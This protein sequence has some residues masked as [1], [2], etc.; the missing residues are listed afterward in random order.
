MP[1]AVDPELFANLLLWICQTPFVASSELEVRTPASVDTLRRRLRNL[2]ETGLISS[3]EVGTPTVDTV[4]RYYPTLLGISSA[5]EFK[6]LSVTEFRR[7]YPVSREW[8]EILLERLDSVIA[9]YRLSGWVGQIEGDHGIHLGRTRIYDTGGLYDSVL[10]M[11]DGR[12]V[13]IVR[14]GAAL[15]E[16]DLGDALRRLSYVGTRPGAVLLIAPTRWHRQRA[17]EI[18]SQL[19]LDSVYVATERGTVSETDWAEPIWHAPTVSIGAMRTLA[20]IV[21]KAA[22]YVIANE[23]RVNG[24]IHRARDR[25]SEW[26]PYGFIPSVA[27]S[28]AA[29]VDPAGL[30]SQSPAANLSRPEKRILDII[31]ACPSM[32]RSNLINR[33]GCTK[34]WISRV[35]KQLEATWG[36][37][38]GHLNPRDPGRGRLS[39]S[40][41]GC[42]YAAGRDRVHLETA[43]DLWSRMPDESGQITGRLARKAERLWLHQDGVYESM[44]QLGCGGSRDDRV[45]WVTSELS[46]DYRVREVRRVITPDA[47]GALEAG[48][49]YIPFFLEFERTAIYPSRIPRRLARYRSLYGDG[50][51]LSA[52]APFPFVLFTFPSESIENRFLGVVADAG[53]SLPILTSNLEV[54]HALGGMGEAWRPAWPLPYPEDLEVPSGRTRTWDPLGE[55]RLAFDSLGST[56]WFREGARTIEYEPDST[57]RWDCLI[58]EA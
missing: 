15:A 33:L 3:I 42:A 45:L 21:E 28:R 14:Q 9:C 40:E 34:G 47:I 55:D 26:D 37:V 10:E 18:V 35:L 53:F 48:G 8:F 58:S 52:M 2:R 1:I 49:L 31:A 30:V 4:P 56:A 13:G 20:E 27:R 50:D 22:R 46:V 5:A 39:L 44:A 57:H 7:E 29:L 36:L 11:P 17:G 19:E 54:L 6:G 16:R 41:L 51:A 24:D 32:K 38:D 12:T 43:R 23:Y 25:G